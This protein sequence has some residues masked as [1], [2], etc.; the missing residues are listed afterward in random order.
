MTPPETHKITLTQT[1]RH[2][3]EEFEADLQDISYQ[4]N[5]EI[6]SYSLDPDEDDGW[7]ET[8]MNHLA[9]EYDEKQEHLNNLK[10]LLAALINAY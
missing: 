5:D 2:L 6:D 10:Q 4:I 7:H 1:L 3:I 8:Q 9:E